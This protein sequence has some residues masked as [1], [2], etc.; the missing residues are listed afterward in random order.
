LG[1]ITDS[2]N[3]GEAFSMFGFMFGLGSLIAPTLG[4]LLADPVGKYPQLFG[5]ITLLR[6]YP[7]L[8][9][10]VVSSLFSLFGLVMGILYLEETLGKRPANK[11]FATCVVEDEMR[12]ITPENLKHYDSLSSKDDLIRRSSPSPSSYS[13]STF[14]DSC[15]CLLCFNYSPLIIILSRSNC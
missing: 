5:H 14:V 15:K 11:R 3:Q 4:G 6:E 7:Y 12:S 10:C 9:P 8:L 13:T 1:E 2:S